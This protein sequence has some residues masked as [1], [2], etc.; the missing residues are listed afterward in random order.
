MNW[1]IRSLSSSKFNNSTRQLPKS[2]SSWYLHTIKHQTGIL[3]GES[4][5]F[6]QPQVGRSLQQRLILTRDLFSKIK[7]PC[8]FEV[9]FSGSKWTAMSRQ[10]GKSVQNDNHLNRDFLVQLW[11]EDKKL[12]SS[13]RKRKRIV[14]HEKH[15]ESIFNNQTS[16]QLPFG[17]WFSGASVAVEK[18]NNR[19][20]PGLK[21]PPLSQ[22]VTGFLEPSSPEEV[23]LFL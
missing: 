5:E 9:N 12:E 23:K 14:K 6:L 2:V 19:L 7:L 10:F 8:W 21:Q 1:L 20:K 3:H 11:V 22:S 17:R 16:F 15:G 18:R 4:P 13:R